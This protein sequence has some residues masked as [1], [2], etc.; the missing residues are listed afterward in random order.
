MFFKPAQA[1]SK[2]FTLTDSTGALVA[3]DSLPA[4]TAYRNGEADAG[5]VLTVASISTGRYKITGTV[6][7]YTQDDVVEVVV[8]ATIATVATAESVDRFHIET[9]IDAA[10]TSRPTM[11]EIEASGVLAMEAT[12]DA[13]GVLAAALPTLAEIEASTVLAKEATVDALPT[14]AEI[15]AG[16]LAASVA[17]LKKYA[18]NKKVLNKSGATWSLVIYD[19]DGTTPLLTKA[20]KDKDGGE[21]TDLAAGVI[22]QELAGM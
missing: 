20:L 2:V 12:V 14:L 7:A 4:A 10:I 8:D 19:N 11:A 21:I 3:A 1:Y 18:Q 15:E 6:P 16:A 13:V 17:L 22:S 9:R 5:F